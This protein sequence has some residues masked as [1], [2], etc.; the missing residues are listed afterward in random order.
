M[1]QHSYDCANWKKQKKSIE[2]LQLTNAWF[3]FLIC[4]T[5]DLRDFLVINVQKVFSF[6]DLVLRQMSLAC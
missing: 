6:K 3:I 2:K 5:L 1:Q 4:V